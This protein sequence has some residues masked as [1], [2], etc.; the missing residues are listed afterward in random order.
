[1]LELARLRIAEAKQFEPRPSAVQHEVAMMEATMR[2]HA[3]MESWVA[4]GVLRAAE[5]HRALSAAIVAEVLEMTPATPPVAAPESQSQVVW[6][7][8]V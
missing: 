4:Q 1:V 6:L 8:G 2:A 3:A 7:Q 5:Q